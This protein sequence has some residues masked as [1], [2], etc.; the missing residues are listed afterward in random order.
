MVDG[1]PVGNLML[2]QAVALIEALKTI[3]ALKFWLMW[4][5]VG[6]VC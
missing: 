2:L 1:L 5:V 6:V 4:D 3:I